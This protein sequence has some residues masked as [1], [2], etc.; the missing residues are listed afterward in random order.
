M[1][2]EKKPHKIVSISIYVSDLEEL[3]AKVAALK[4]RGIRRANRS[5]L[6]RTA[7]TA[8][9]V[10]PADATLP[11]VRDLGGGSSCSDEGCEDC[12]GH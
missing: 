5:W 7:L 9:A 1:R 10:P 2:R 11:H 6:I 3:D 4:A 12:Y 8:F